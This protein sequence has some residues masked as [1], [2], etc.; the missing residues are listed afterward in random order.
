MRYDK[1]M[2]LAIF[3]GTGRTGQL[4]VAQALAAGHDVAVLARTPSRLDITRERLRVVGGDALD[5][6]RAREAV[7]GADAIISLLGPQRDAPP[8][9][10]SRAT[11]N[12]LAAADAYGARRVIAVACDAAS[13]AAAADMRAAAD[14]VAASPLDWTLVRV[15][16]LTDPSRQQLA[17][18]LL[19]QLTDTT[20]IRQTAALCAL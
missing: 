8:R 10:V 17:A 2:K 12:I 4:L 20:R 16:R 3:G 19:R 5:P 11:A 15:P 1:N 14:V 6:G 7:A 13:G 18:F 9:M